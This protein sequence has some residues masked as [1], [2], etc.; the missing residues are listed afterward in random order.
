MIVS[1]RANRLARGWSGGAMV[2]G[3]LPLVPKRSSIAHSLSL[4]SERRPDMT[5]ILL[6]RT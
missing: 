3:K 1:S 2:L 6:K 4:S 5:E